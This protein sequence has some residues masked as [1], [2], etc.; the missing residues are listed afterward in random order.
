MSFH[1]GCRGGCFWAQCMPG[2][3]PLEVREATPGA[4]AFGRAAQPSFLVPR[5]PAEPP[6]TF[7]TQS[8]VPWPTRIRTASD[9]C[10]LWL[11]LAVATEIEHGGFFL[12][13]PVFAGAGAILWFVLGSAPAELPMVAWFAAFAVVV[14]MAGPGRRL[15]RNLALAGLLCVTGMFA[16]QFETWSKA[17]I[18]LDSGDDDDHR[19]C[20]APGRRW[21][22]PAA[23]HRLRLI[24][25]IAR[26]KAAT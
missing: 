23:L 12:V 3:R 8:F 26:D 13:S 19:P 20:R 9:R 1:S 16:A 7:R 18:I 5:V 10:T 2:L 6:L 11:R 15:I 17:T 25:A 22:W 24:D 4:D 14:L 21:P